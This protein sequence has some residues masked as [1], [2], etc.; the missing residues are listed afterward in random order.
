MKNKYKL[1]RAIVFGIIV[2]SPLVYK[3][4]S[5]GTEENSTS[6]LSTLGMNDLW[7]NRDDYI[8]QS[9]VLD[10]DINE[11]PSSIKKIEL[12]NGVLEYNTFEAKDVPELTDEY[13]I[14]TTSCNLEEGLY[15]KVKTLK[16]TR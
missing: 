5:Y 12:S 2:A 4:C 7:T 11:I 10:K 1:Q 3:S 15:E 8:S 6:T 16:F 13:N 14:L 9:M